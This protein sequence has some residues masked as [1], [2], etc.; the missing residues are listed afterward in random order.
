MSV[1]HVCHRSVF[2]LLLNNTVKLLC[3][4]AMENA[5][6]SRCVI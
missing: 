5:G 2:R 6:S 3:P 4:E 1:L